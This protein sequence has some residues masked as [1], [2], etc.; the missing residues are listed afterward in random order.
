MNI[1]A[2]KC[3]LTTMVIFW[4]QYMLNMSIWALWSH[5]HKQCTVSIVP[6]CR[7]VVI[8]R[9]KP[10]VLESGLLL[11]LITET[12]HWMSL[13]WEI[14]Y[15]VFSISVC[16]C[17]KIVSE[18]PHLRRK[19]WDFLSSNTPTVHRK[20]ILKELHLEMFIAYKHN[21]NVMYESLLLLFFFFLLWHVM[22]GT[23]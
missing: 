10:R 21:T 23:V 1:I 2:D 6:Y 17:C 19:R 9:L 16:L 7:Q 14:C 3:W 11:K 18:A 20:P 8:Y 13:W 22:W 15:N 5:C 12:W 4:M